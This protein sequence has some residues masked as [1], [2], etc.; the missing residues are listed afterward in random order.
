MAIDGAGSITD[1]NVFIFPSD[2]EIS[3]TDLE[4]FVKYHGT[5]LVPALKR[6]MQ[7][8]KG[9]H[10]ILDQADRGGH[11]PDNRLVVNL[12]SYIV[13]TFNGYFIGLPPK[14]TLDD[15]GANDV[16]Q[17]WNNTNS[18]Q[19][20]LSEVSKL[21]DVYGY[22][23][24]FAYQN[25]DS[26]TGVAYSSPENSFMIYDDT[27]SSN[28]LAFVRYAYDDD[29]E[30]HG[31]LYSADGAYTFDSHYTAIDAFPN[32]YG[33]VPAVEFVE[34]AERQGIADKVTTLIDGIDKAISQKANQVEYFD[35]AYLK[36]LG[37]ELPEN[38]AGEPILDISGNQ[39]IYS[40]DAT[41][42]DA[43]A[44][45][46]TKPDGDTMQENHIDRLIKLIYQI[47]KV[48]NP[49]DEAFSGNQ[50]GVALKQK[51]RPMQNMAKSK[52][53]KFTQALR[54]F[55][56]IV[57]AGGLIHDTA[58]W[59]QLKFKFTYNDVEDIA[60]EA[61]TLAT[62]GATVSKETA[63][64]TASFVDDPKTELQRIA[65]EQVAQVK[66]A[67]DNASTYGP[68]YLAQDGESDG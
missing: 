63:L 29:N 43:E 4:A 52:E 35:N 34:N 5:N 22:A 25:E 60:D 58:A 15:T 68:D 42:S 48:P 20:K 62:L 55:Y 41:S 7:D 38:D 9:H 37:L 61:N 36:I 18:L 3:P 50:T 46:I 47:S 54:N 13:D 21:A 64:S 19:D 28:P 56:K 27:V 2:T 6:K 49:N 23:Y 45:F 17:A 26:Q 16:L 14:I 1:N 31:T 32:I 39:V 51:M 57:F 10:A 12:N 66:Q 30:L 65:D 44:D 67:A 11:R 53:R 24:L 59:Q 40:P 8:Y 33:V